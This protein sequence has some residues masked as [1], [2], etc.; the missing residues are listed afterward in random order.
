VAETTTVARQEGGVIPQGTTRKA[1]EP[2]ELIALAVIAAAAV[3]LRLWPIG[4]VATDYQDEGVYWQSL[5]AMAAGQPLFTA[6]FSSQPPFFLLS[7]YPFYL[8]L[9][10]TLVAARL[11]VA[12]YSLVGLGAIYYAGRALGG[13]WAG[14][15]ACALLAIDPL[16]LTES[17][18]LQAEAPS[19]AFALLAVALAADALR[20]AGGPRRAL[21]AASGVALGLGVMT[22]LSDI[23]TLAPVAILLAAPLYAPSIDARAAARPRVSSRTALA[24]ALPDLAL[25]AAGLVVA[26]AAVLA[27]FLVAHAPVYDQAVRFHL[28]TERTWLAHGGWHGNI[29]VLRADL[30]G[31]YALPY[32]ALAVGACLLAVWRRTWVVAV[33]V[34][35]LLA[36]LAFLVR[37]LPLY[38]HHLVVVAPP[39]ALLAGLALTPLAR[40]AASPH[41]RRQGMPVQALVVGVVTVLVALSLLF[42]ARQGIADDRAAARPVSP[43]QARV[44]RALRAAT[45]PD[46]SIATDNQ[47]VAGLAGRTVVPQLVDTS[48]VRIVTGC[49]APRYMSVGMVEDLITRAHV[50]VI[51][52]GSPRFSIPCLGPVAFP[53]WVRAHYPHVT[54]FGQGYALYSK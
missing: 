25:C 44:A 6:V 38:S 51:L 53:A 9:G 37:Q 32:A 16:Y 52:F 13:R 36:S 28:V 7:L 11:T 45:R 3:A 46:E 33:P 30:T 23:V 26:C 14:P 21:A 19:L 15:V 29:S 47:Y 17:H 4:G 54:D 34:A 42:E 49:L 12:L 39:L 18:T 2:L 31:A 8:L 20:R 40:F 48:Q 41:A 10:Q 50:R 22:K 35:W 27:P 43:L 1:G 24:S 5:R